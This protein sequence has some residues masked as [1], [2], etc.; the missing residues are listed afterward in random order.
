MHFGFSQPPKCDLK[1]Q[2]LIVGNFEVVI[3]MDH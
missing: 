1:Y 3:E 2:P